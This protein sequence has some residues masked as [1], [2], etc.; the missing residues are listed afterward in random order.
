MSGDAVRVAGIVER[1]YRASTAERFGVPR[2]V[3]VHVM[4]RQ[5]ARPEARVHAHLFVGRGLEG[6]AEA[7]ALRQ[8]LAVGAR[9]VAVGQYLVPLTGDGLDVVL[10][11]CSRITPMGLE[12]QELQPLQAVAA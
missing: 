11:E 5:E 10:R 6:D 1:T 7:D 8:R 3:M 4:L 2:R 12:Q 9:V